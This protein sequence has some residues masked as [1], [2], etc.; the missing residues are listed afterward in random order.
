MGTIYKLLG[1][2]ALLAGAWLLHSFY[3]DYRTNAR[4]YLLAWD[5]PA[6]VHERFLEALAKRGVRPESTEVRAN[7]RYYTGFVKHR[8][9]L[10]NGC[11]PRAGAWSLDSP[12]QWVCRRPWTERTYVRIVHPAVSYEE[13]LDKARQAHPRSTYGMVP[14]QAS[15]GGSPSPSQRAASLW[16]GVIA[17]AAMILTSLAL[18]ASILASWLRAR[19]EF[20]P[21]PQPSPVF[22]TQGTMRPMTLPDRL[23][24]AF[25]D[26]LPVTVGEATKDCPLVVTEPVDYVSVEYAV[27]KYLMAGKEWKKLRQ[28]VLR[29]NGRIVDELVFAVRDGPYSEYAERSFYFDVTTGFMRR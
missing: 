18:L 26:D 13:A 22:A 4:H 28:N 2:V 23:K 3:V 6:G 12:S 8:S 29:L 10:A 7:P 19:N 1:I 25:G 5:S 24:D 17:P 9:D 16:L 14:S 27:A 21:S 15:A 20:R 11:R